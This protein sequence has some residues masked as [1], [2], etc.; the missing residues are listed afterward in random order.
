M[1]AVVT[2]GGKQLR[3]S[4][5]DV[6]RVE[7]IDA[8]IGDTVELDKVC[9]LA[10]DDALVVDPESLRGAKVVCEVLRQGRRKKIRVFKMKRRKKYARTQGHRQPYTELRVRDIAM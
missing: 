4:P 10:S 8:L 2:A 3:V 6:V 9:L 1:Y 7:K 5:G